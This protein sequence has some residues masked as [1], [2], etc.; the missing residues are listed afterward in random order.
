MVWDI[1][2]WKCR[3]DGPADWHFHPNASLLEGR[4]FQ[5]VKLN[6]LLKCEACVSILGRGA[7]RIFCKLTVANMTFNAEV[8]IRFW[9]EFSIF[10]L[11]R[12]QSTFFSAI[13]LCHLKYQ[14]WAA[15]PN[16]FPRPQFN[17]SSHLV[18]FSASLPQ[19]ILICQSSFLLLSSKSCDWNLN[20]VWDLKLIS[21][22]WE[23]ESGAVKIRMKV[24]D[25]LHTLRSWGDGSLTSSLDTGNMCDRLGSTNIITLHSRNTLY[26]GHQVCLLTTEH[27]KSQ[28]VKRPMRIQLNLFLLK[29]STVWHPDYVKSFRDLLQAVCLQRSPEQVSLCMSSSLSHRQ[30]CNL[31]WFLI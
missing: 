6:I 27:V 12:C 20:P 19:K 11:I 29:T 22:H 16:S 3:T 23:H 30:L 26:R 13:T 9:K 8:Q 5:F 31:F 15:L 10:S 4:T 28:N 24:W 17:V 7:N 25:P 2:L 18:K 1:L 21:M 14:S